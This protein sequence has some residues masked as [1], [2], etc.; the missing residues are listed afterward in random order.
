MFVLVVFVLIVNN[1]EYRELQMTNLFKKIATL[2]SM[3]TFLVL[4]SM[5]GA[6]ANGVDFKARGWD[7]NISGNVNG[8]FTYS[9]CNNKDIVSGGLTCGATS[10]KNTSE[11]AIENG[12]VPTAIIF[13]GKTHEGIYDISAVFG[14]YPSLNINN[15]FVR[16]GGNGNVPFGSAKADIR[17]VFLTF[18]NEQMGT[19]EI[20]RDIGL[21]SKQAIL[22]DMTLAGVGG[23]VGVAV[24]GHTPLGR[25]G[26]G[27]LYPE[28]MPQFFIYNPRASWF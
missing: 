26:L 17:Q 18:G 27:Y 2:C 4:L 25:I 9:F 12:L 19:F 23:N 22:A 1:N 3:S 8:F 20:G 11:T 5:G 16:A 10:T 13:T 21:F 24:P 15:E 6:Y 7:F 14:L 28:W